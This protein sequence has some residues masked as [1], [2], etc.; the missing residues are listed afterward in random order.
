MGDDFM[1]GLAIAGFCSFGL[2]I[3]ILIGWFVNDDTTKDKDRSYVKV[4]IAISGSAV[5]FV[6]LFAP[7][8][9]RE[10]WFY[11]I[12]LLVGLLISPLPAVY[13]QWFYSRKSI[14]ALFPK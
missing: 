5:S 13:F 8:I 9:G 11:P 7:L 14:K 3:G 10:R 4:V 1:D 2:F 6:P 12:A